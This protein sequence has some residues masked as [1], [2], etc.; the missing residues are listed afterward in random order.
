MGK[1]KKVKARSASS[2]IREPWAGKFSLL[3]LLINI[4]IWAGLRG[5]DIVIMTFL[6]TVVAFTGYLL[7]LSGRK[8]LR[9]QRGSVGGESIVTIAYWGN[10]LLFLL[11]FLMFSYSLAIGV[12]RGDFL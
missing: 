5:M 1:W 3:L 4:F 2:H 11:T 12:L 8:F 9:R 10:L 6:S 7:A